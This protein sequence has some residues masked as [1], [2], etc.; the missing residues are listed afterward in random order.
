MTSFAMVDLPACL[1]DESHRLAFCY[2]HVHVHDDRCGRVVPEGHVFED[3]LAL[4]RRDSLRIGVFGNA[5]FDVE[6]GLELLYRRLPLLERVVLLDKGLDR[7]E[8]PVQV[9]EEHDQSA[10][11]ERLVEDH[12]VAADTEQG[13]LAQICKA[14]V[15]G[16]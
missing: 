8:E 14:G 10:R 5:R 11:G 6:Q 1:P 13:G 15:P 3:D 9:Q 2:P 4:D 7:G 12:H 16:P